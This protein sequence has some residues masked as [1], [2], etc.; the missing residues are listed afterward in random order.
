MAWAVDVMGCDRTDEID[1]SNV[2][3][4]YRG[5]DDE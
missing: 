3:P 4:K 2:D 5:L 1:K